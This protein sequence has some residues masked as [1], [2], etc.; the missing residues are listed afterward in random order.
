MIGTRFVIAELD[1]FS[2]AGTGESSLTL[3]ALTATEA[4][5]NDGAVVI[6]LA[7]Q[8]Q[9]KRRTANGATIILGLGIADLSPGQRKKGTL[10]PVSGGQVVSVD[11]VVTALETLPSGT[12]GLRVARVQVNGLSSGEVPILFL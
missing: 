9:V 6:G 1:S 11:L 3:T 7:G 12:G 4:E 8:D 2:G 10:M 5:F